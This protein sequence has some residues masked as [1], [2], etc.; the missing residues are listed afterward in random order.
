MTP[1]CSRSPPGVDHWLKGEDIGIMSE[2]RNIL[3]EPEWAMW[4][5]IIANVW[6]GIPFFAITLLAALK[7]IPG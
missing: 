5:P 6:F 4:G 3:S 7:S 2:P 1:A